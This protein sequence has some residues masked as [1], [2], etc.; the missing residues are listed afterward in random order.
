MLFRSVPV[1]LVTRA[2]LFGG[3]GFKRIDEAAFRGTFHAAKAGFYA[4]GSLDGA[5]WKLLGGRDFSKE[6]PSLCRDIVASFAR[7]C[8]CRYFAFAFVGE[9]RGDARLAF[10]EVAA[11]SDFERRIR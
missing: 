2:C 1:A 8:A 7:S 5:R 4:L 9:L 10:V 11:Q 3:T 6:S